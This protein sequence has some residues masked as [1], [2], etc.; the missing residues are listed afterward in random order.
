MH[1][2]IQLAKDGSVTSGICTSPEIFIHVLTERGQQSKMIMQWG[3]LWPMQC[4]KP[5]INQ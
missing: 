2:K 1:V 5:D 4:G 3:S